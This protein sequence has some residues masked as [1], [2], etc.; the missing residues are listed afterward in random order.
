MSHVEEFGM[1]FETYFIFTLLAVFSVFGSAGNAVVLYVFSTA[2]DDLVS[3]LFI[4]VLAVVDFITCLVIIPYTIVVELISYEVR[5]DLL[6]KLYQFLITSNI[7]FSALIMTAI[8]VDRYFCICHPFSRLLTLRRARVVVSILAAF[9]SLLGIVGSLT[10]SV[11]QRVSDVTNATEHGT[12]TQ[13]TMTLPAATDN[14]S[15]ELDDET[16][17]TG[18][19]DPTDLI[20]SSHFASAF[21]IC[22][23]AIFVV[24]LGI[25]VVLY[26][27]IYRSVLRQRRKRQKMKAAPIRSHIPSVQHTTQTQTTWTS[28]NLPTAVHG[29]SAAVSQRDNEDGDNMCLDASPEV[30]GMVVSESPAAGVNAANDRSHA[31]MVDTGSAAAAAAAETARRNRIANVKTAAMLFVVT[32]VFTVSFLPALAMT[33]YILPYNRTIFYMYF[34]NNVANPIIYSFMN[35]NFRKRLVLLFC[36]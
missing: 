28:S 10:H 18:Y 30:V 14:Q 34:A 16:V 4:I 8:A 22:H 6:C 27:V 11:Y 7:P 23:T 29:G 5:F 2:K 32:L 36:K 12:V 17:Y 15:R 26:S 33:L 3:T 25:V 24:C 9:A 35:S 13:S 21:Q 1:T 20:L 31:G 19:C